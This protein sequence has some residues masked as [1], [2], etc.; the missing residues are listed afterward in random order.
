MILKRGLNRASFI[1]GSSTH[2]TRIERL[3]VE[4]GSQFARRWRA[5]FYRLEALH[6]LDRTNANHLWLLHRLFLD[7]INRDCAE[8]QVQWNAHPISGAGH[9]Q[10][11]ND[12]FLLGQ[13]ENGVYL[14]DCVGVHPDVIAEL[15]GTHGAVMRRAPGE[16]GAG[17]LDDEDVPTTFDDRIDL[18][19][20]GWE[21]MI[22]GIDAANSHHFH[23]APV[24]VPK[25]NN[26]FSE[27]TLPIFDAALAEAHRLL[28]V[29]AGYGLLP[30]E[31]ENGAY[32]AFEILKSGRKGSKELRVA[33]PDVLWRA[34]AELWGR[35]LATLD[36]LT[37]MLE[38]LE[39]E[40][41]SQSQSESD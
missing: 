27:D 1:W 8:F 23:H 21:D 22:E 12:M 34:R 31:W 4:V 38:S 6:R 41:E 13:L 15:Y 36:E 25:H 30:D 33:L 35:A 10:S 29:P 20:E 37:Y 40:S 2:N 3:W 7:D 5:F 16:T 28:V 24:P 18:D 19:E 11:P 14:D 26:P 17:Q 39:S 9:D 32:P